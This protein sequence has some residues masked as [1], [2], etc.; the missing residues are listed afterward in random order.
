MS[1]NAAGFA[2]LV[3]SA[4]IAPRKH[5]T[6]QEKVGWFCLLGGGSMILFFS[7]RVA[8]QLWFGRKRR[9]HGRCAT[10]GYDLRATPDRC[11]ECGT[12][13]ENRKEKVSR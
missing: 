5:L 3:L 13:P 11:P 4:A 2:S 7:V 9:A 12:V 10:C 1:L 8:T 6:S